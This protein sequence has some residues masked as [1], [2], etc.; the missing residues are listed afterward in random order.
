MRLLILFTISILTLFEPMAEARRHSRHRERHR[1]SS[2]DG[3]ETKE[4]CPNGKFARGM[5]LTNYYT[6]VLAPVKCKE[7]QVGLMNLHSKE[8]GDACN[9][10]TINGVVKRTEGAGT[11]LTALGQFNGVLVSPAGPIAEIKKTGVRFSETLPK[12][13]PEGMFHV[14]EPQ[15]PVGYGNKINGEPVCLDPFR[16]IACPKQHAIGEVAFIP[17]TVG[18]QFPRY[19]GQPK[20]IYEN[21]PGS[22]GY[23]ACGDIGVAIKGPHVDIFVAFINPASPQ[24][25]F[26]HLDGPKQGVCWA[27]KD[28]DDPEHRYKYHTAKELNPHFPWLDPWTLAFYTNGFFL[29][30][31]FQLPWRIK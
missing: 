23:F 13:S 15:C 16:M 24:N 25:P 18:I 21:L 4:I 17:A 29:A 9:L 1:E 31:A 12:G 28:E 7:G 2:P 10:G 20:W 22:D 30:E 3:N 6:P 8:S 14:A 5:R 11:V 19:P 27:P 26:R